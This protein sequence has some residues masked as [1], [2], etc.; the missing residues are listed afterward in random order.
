MPL[1]RFAS[2]PQRIFPT[3]RNEEKIFIISRRHIVDFF[4]FLMINISLFIVP[5]LIFIVLF[6]NIIGVVST[7][8]VE[9]R[10]L[11]I[12]GT[13]S[14]YLSVAVIFLTGWITYYYDSFIVTNDRIVEV[15]QN[16]LF[17]RNIHEL[18]F[19]QIED[20]SYSTK[21]ILATL[22]GAG[23]IEIQ[24]A[25]TQ[26]NF[27]V[28]NIAKPQ[29]STEIIQQLALQVKNNKPTDQIIPN[30]PV[31]GVIN[32]KIIRKEGKKPAI[33][34]F[35]GNLK[36]KIKEFNINQCKPITLREKLDNWWWGYKEEIFFGN[37]DKDYK[38]GFSKKMRGDDEEDQY[39]K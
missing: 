14:Y 1:C 8:S 9:L 23:N 38:I 33:M 2:V 10:E 7:A 34:N 31:V 28:R 26:R 29:I 30:L 25:G 15:V 22:F 24:T 32:G 4:P 6:S 13:M 39:L 12:I 21:G 35:E 17:S 3:Q 27:I 36:S 19:E 11:I 5:I 18:A 16:G 37:S 20:V